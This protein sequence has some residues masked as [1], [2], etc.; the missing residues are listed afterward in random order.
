MGIVGA[1]LLIDLGLLGAANL[2]IARKPEANELIAKLAPYQGYAGAVGALWGIWIIIHALL[3][4][5]LI[6]LALVWWATYLSM[7]VIMF[8]LG[9]LLGVG[10]LKTWIKDPTAQEK[11]DQLIERLAPK[12]GLLGLIGLGLGVWGLIANFMFL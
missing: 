11:M 6:K 7:G 3:N 1:A 5:G 4:L 2:I 12:Q 10:M 8:G 9:L